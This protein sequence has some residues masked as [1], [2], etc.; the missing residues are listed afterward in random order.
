MLS[1]KRL[2]K[3][4]IFNVDGRAKFRDTTRPVRCVSVR[5]VH[6]GVI[7]PLND[8]MARNLLLTQ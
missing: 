4:L 3:I 5:N 2:Y 8:S 1:F 7:Q 6:V